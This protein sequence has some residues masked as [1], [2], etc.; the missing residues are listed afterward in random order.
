MK[1]VTVEYVSSAKTHSLIVCEVKTCIWSLS[2]MFR[3]IW[4]QNEFKWHTHIILR[5]IFSI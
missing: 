5:W 1:V 4:V 3:Y 2:D